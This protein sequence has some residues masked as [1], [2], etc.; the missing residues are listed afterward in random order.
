MTGDPSLPDTLLEIRGL[1]TLLGGRRGFLQKARP[2][3]RA[4]NGVDLSIRRGETFGVVGESG[5]GKT[6]LGRTILGVQRETEGEIVLNGR[7][8][9]RLSRVE[10]RRVRRDV[11]Y[12]HQDAAASLDPWWR[13]DRSLWEPLVV[14]AATEGAEARMTE[15]LAAVGLDASLLRRYPHE[16][17][18]GQIR[19]VAL[20]RIL[21]LLPQL[22]ILD[23]PTSGLDVSV[24]AGVLGLL[25]DLKKRLNLTYIFISHDLSVVRLICDR[26]AI[27]YLGKVV[28]QAPTDRLFSA[29][30]HPYTRALIAA[31]PNLARRRL[32]DEDAVK[33]DI[34]DAAD[35]PSGCAF[36]ERCRFATERCGRDVPR[37]AAVGFEHW[38]SCHNWDALPAVNPE[39][40]AQAEIGLGGSANHPIITDSTDKREQT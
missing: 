10:A 3:V 34:P 2:P 18:G 20:A 38:V 27:M 22:V 32:P 17:S 33:G 13:I 30:S 1:V 6:T 7:P 31:A 15:I 4:V 26:V 9:S 16:L 12:V 19:R 40:P 5:C 8:V 11:Q 35:V 21:L 14:H 37:P 28:E 23:E 36:R 25:L 24:Q 39:Y 29:P